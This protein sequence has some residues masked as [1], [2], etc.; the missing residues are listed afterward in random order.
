MLVVHHGSSISTC[1]CRI[2]FTR[3]V[4]ILWCHWKKFRLSCLQTIFAY[5]LHNDFCYHSIHKHTS[6]SQHVATQM[7]TSGMHRRPF[8]G[9][10]LFGMWHHIYW[11]MSH[12]I[13]WNVASYLLECGIIFI[14]MWHHLYWNVASY[15]L[16]CG[17]IFTGMLHHIY[18]N[19]AS[20]L[21]ECSIIFISDGTIY[22]SESA[23]NIY[24]IEHL[25]ENRNRIKEIE[26][27]IIRFFFN[28][29]VN[30]LNIYYFLASL[31]I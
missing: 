16:E 17:I 9:R 13:Y 7:M 4:I 2:S 3:L 18:W 11:N 12:H 25:I 14:G 27:K 10:H 23:S 30:R 5:A 15:L 22:L 6:R 19:V 21:L 29:T 24:R 20:Y 28:L 31:H 26:L 8:E 1:S